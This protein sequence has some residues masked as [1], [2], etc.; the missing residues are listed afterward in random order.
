SIVL[1]LLRKKIKNT[2]LKYIRNSSVVILIL[3]ILNF[4]I[5]NLVHGYYELTILGLL[6]FLS[7]FIS[8]HIKT[9]S[10]EV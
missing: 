4:V 7:A 1:L 6:L 3:N 8:S 2:E 5:L 10:D 9:K